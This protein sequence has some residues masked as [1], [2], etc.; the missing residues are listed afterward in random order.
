MRVMKIWPICLTMIQ[1]SMIKPHQSSSA[2]DP[3]TEPYY[4]PT[5]TNTGCSEH[6]DGDG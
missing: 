2:G 3:T 1:L 5:V 6:D 4:E